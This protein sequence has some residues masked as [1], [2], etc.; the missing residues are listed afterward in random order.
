MDLLDILKLKGDEHAS[1][2][3]PPN[4]KLFDT[5]AKPISPVLQRHMAA[6]NAPSGSSAPVFNF[7]LG[8]EIINILRPPA[9][10][11]IVAPVPPPANIAPNYEPPCLLLLHHSRV[12]GQDMPL[13][14]FCAKY[15][16]GL[17]TLKKFEDNYYMDA[18]VLQFATIDELKQMEFR[19]GEIADLQDVV[20]LWLVLNNA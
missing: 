1:L 19:L 13:S 10:Q 8:N 6:Q 16:L 9:S 5:T 2:Q 18:C 11:P 20:E 7:T 3:R 14:G 4:H 12:A 15:G 17:H